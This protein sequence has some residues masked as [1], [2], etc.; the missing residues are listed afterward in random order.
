M[1]Q[2]ADQPHA[3]L[4]QARQLGQA[5]AGPRRR[6]TPQISADNKTITVKIRKGVKFAPAG[7]PRGQGRGHQVRVRACV[8][9]A[10][11]RSGY[12]GTY[13]RSIVGA[14]Q[15]RTRAAIKP[16][17]GITRR[18]TTRSCSSSRSRRRRWSSQALVM[19]ITVPVPE[20]VRDEV[21]QEEPVDLRPARRLHRPVHGQERRA[22]GKLDRPYAGQADRARPQPELGRKSTDYRPAYLDAITIDEGNDRPATVASRRDARAAAA[23]LLRRRPPPAQVAEAGRHAAT[24]TRSRS[25]RRGGTRYI[26]LNTTIKPFDNINVR[27]ARDRRLRPQRAAPDARRHVRR[28]HRHDWIPPDIPGL[29]RGRR[30]QAGPDLDFLQEPERRHDAWP[31]STCSPPSRGVPIR[32]R[33]V[34]PGSEKFLMVATNAD[35]GKET[36]EVAKA[37]FE[38][39]GLQAPNFRIVP[40]DTLYT[41]FCGVPSKKV[42]DLPERRLVQG[43]RRPAVDAGADVQRQR[44]SSSR[45]T[46]TGR[47]S[48]TRRSTRP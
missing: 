40:Q 19:P 21:R 43:L 27:K 38:K 7:E 36:A 26:A 10:T 11:S 15:G 16:I 5:G 42:A 1:V 14:P 22:T 45:A 35:P 41:K 8:L 2:Y 28:R 23:G 6:A 3:V 46:S 37:Q 12:A 32:Q 9:Q 20:G 18:T 44:T 25:S 34:R 13:F 30:A 47:S 4:V 24:R 39:L 33:Q 31:R 17:S 29:R 48:T